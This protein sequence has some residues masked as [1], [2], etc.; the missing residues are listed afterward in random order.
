MSKGPPR[1]SLGDFV[2]GATFGDGIL[3]GFAVRRRPDL[4]ILLL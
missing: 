2:S 1:P 4:R 3:F